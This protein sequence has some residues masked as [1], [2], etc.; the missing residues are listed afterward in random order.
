MTLSVAAV[1]GPRIRQPLS[2]ACVHQKYYKLGGMI[3]VR[4][5]EI[6]CTICWTARAADF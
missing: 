4:C 1:R 5:L 6:D 3:P 2:V